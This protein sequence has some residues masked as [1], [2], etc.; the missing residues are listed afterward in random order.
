MATMAVQNARKRNKKAPARKRANARNT[1]NTGT[2]NKPA[3]KRRVRRAASSVAGGAK[4]AGGKYVTR[5]KKGAV[6]NLKATGI[7]TAGALGGTLAAG[8]II[9][10]LK[11]KEGESE[12]DFQ[13]R[14][15][16]TTGITNAGLVAGGVLLAPVLPLAGV[17]LGVA[18]LLGLI[19]QGLSQAPSKDAAGNPVP[20]SLA[21][22][23][24]AKDKAEALA[25]PKGGSAGSGSGQSSG[26]SGV[27]N[28]MP[29]GVYRDK[30][31]GIPFQWDGKNARLIEPR[32]GSSRSGV[33]GPNLQTYGERNR[34]A[35][36]NRAAGARQRQ[37]GR[38]ALPQP[39]QRAG[40]AGPN[41]ATYGDYLAAQGRRR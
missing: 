36:T 21:Q 23:L 39:G 29:P 5:L 40:V 22:M 4:R 41:V 1:S 7:A 37:Q 10:G 24:E 3:R 18:G 25:L 15:V 8:A 16:V 30:K 20:N 38:R 17:G 6:P 14:R 28:A 12:A 13:K 11:R 33:A 27:G 2:T 26:A 35:G 34:A 19:R 9:H 31:T 32:G